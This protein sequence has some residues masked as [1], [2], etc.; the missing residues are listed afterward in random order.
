MSRTVP[1]SIINSFQNLNMS[2]ISIADFP[3]S[4]MTVTVHSSAREFF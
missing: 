3:R 2:V 1:Q 4:A